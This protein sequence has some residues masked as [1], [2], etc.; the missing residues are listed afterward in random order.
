MRMLGVR[1]PFGV[2]ALGLVMFAV[3]APAIAQKDFPVR[4]VRLVN[5]FAPGG[6][7]DLVSRAVAAGLTEIWNQQVIVDNRAGGGTT[8]GTEIVARA[9]PDGYTM[10]CTSSAIA[11][12][13]TMYRSLRFDT[14]RDLTPVV[15]VV[16]SFSILAVHPAFP[17]KSVKEL[18]ALAKAQ[19]GQI[20]AASSGTGSTNHLILE[21]FKSMAQVDILHVPYK[22]GGPAV[23]DLMSG[24][25]KMFFNAASTILP[26]MR[27]GRVRGLATSAAQ[28]TE[29]APDLP[30][31]AEA[32]VPGFEAATWNGVYAPR[33]V[34]AQLVQRW[35][36]AINR[37]LKTSKA[38]EHFRRNQFTI[39][40]GSSASFAEYHKS[41]TARW[42]EV[43]R[44][45][46]I[47]PQ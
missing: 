7:V 1:A 39:A 32:G 26:L 33:G 10:L 29:D 31:V 4:P 38:Q 46:G 43:I 41:E 28:R 14:L 5:P 34:S 13:P 37:Y 2:V 35:N 16:S 18:I 30:T 19:P 9:E 17:P 24:Q 45:A 20:A 22:G 3:G 6:S 23:A 36:E 25:V 42:G 21:M 12:M 47:K 40:G 8:I 44:T 27:S 11:I 15:H